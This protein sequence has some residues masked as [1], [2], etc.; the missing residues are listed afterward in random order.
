MKWISLISSLLLVLSQPSFGN[1][2]ADPEFNFPERD[3]T[4]GQLLNHIHVSDIAYLIVVRALK[5]SDLAPLEAVF[6]GMHETFATLNYPALDYGFFEQLFRQR[7][8]PIHLVASEGKPGEQ[9]A[10]IKDGSPR[11][12]WIVAHVN[13]EA[14]AKQ[15]KASLGL[16]DE[17]NIRRLDQ[18]GLLVPDE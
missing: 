9:F 8:L 14:V 1:D 15:Q 12:Y 11:K 3:A 4:C 18:A 17:E 10:S 2:Q 13:R 7:N 16:S 5:F 6:A